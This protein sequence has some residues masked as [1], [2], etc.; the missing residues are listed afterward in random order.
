MKTLKAKL[1][2][3]AASV[4]ALVAL[5]SAGQLY[6]LDGLRSSNQELEQQA[7]RFSGGVI[8]LAVQLQAMRFDI[9][10]VQQ[11]LT[12]I[13]ATR[14]L[15]ELNDGFDL[16]AEFAQSFEKDS[17]AARKL[18][19]DLGYADVVDGIDRIRGL[20]PTYYAAGRTMAEAYVQ[21]GPE[22]GNAF[23]GSFDEAASSLT[24]EVDKVFAD[25]VK[26]LARERAVLD[27]EAQLSL[28]AA[29][30]ATWMNVINIVVVLVGLTALCAGIYRFGLAPLGKLAQALN[31]ITAGDYTGELTESRREDEIGNVAKSILILRD[32]AAEREQLQAAALHEEQ[33]R[34]Q[35]LRQREAIVAE[36]RNEVNGLIGQ[37][38][39]N[40]QRLESTATGLARLAENTDDNARD[41]AQAS[42][43]ALDNVQAVAAATDQ[44]SRSIEEI[45]RRLSVTT[46]VVAEAA[47]TT[48]QTNVKVARL[49]D[50]AEEIGEVVQL[51]STIAEQTNLLALNATIEAA[52][53]GDAGKGFAVVANEVKTL[54]TQTAK[55]TESITAQIAEIQ[56]ATGDAAASIQEIARIMGEISQETTIIASAV[57]EQSSATDEIS[58]SVNEAANGTQTTNAAVAGLAGNAGE[59]TEAASHVTGAVQAVSQRTQGLTHQ[60]E[61]FISNLSA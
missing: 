44:L 49:S 21:S 35:R 8:D 25:Q 14:G 12:D 1:V 48:Q 52:R 54:A 38:N 22:A 36:F 28:S 17:A 47:E 10:Q 40:M 9:V 51:I 43:V 46:N 5:C 37:V 11:W 23:M 15:D 24:E 42:Q 34:S 33:A 4:F 60:I 41:A 7:R 3:V 20:F 13:S 29:R 59:T 58:R 19:S 39:E 57:T 53:A 18:A 45:N 6:M 31:R 16:A 56:S 32:K 26:V 55:A 2:I 50:A 61:K 30:D 27:E